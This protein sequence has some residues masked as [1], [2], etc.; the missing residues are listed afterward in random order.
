MPSI[1]R[2]LVRH[3]AADVG[4]R[5][6]LAI[7]ATL[8]FGQWMIRSFPPWDL[9]DAAYQ[10]APIE[11]APWLLGALVV[12]VLLARPLVR[13]L[14]CA[15]EVRQ[16][17]HLPIAAGRWRW[18]HG[19]QLVVL[20]LPVHAAV[21]YGV[22]PMHARADAC[23][24][25]LASI[26]GHVGVR[27]MQATLVDR[28]S[29]LR[30]FAG[31]AVAMLVG[32]VLVVADAYLAAALGSITAALGVRRLGRPFPEP[33]TRSS[34]ARPWPL[35]RPELARARLQLGCLWHRDRTMVWLTIGVQSA[36]V[37]LAAI[38]AEHLH[39]TFPDDARW[40][41]QLAACLAGAM[42]MWSAVRS[43]RAL[44]DDRWVLDPLIGTRAID[45][46]GRVIAAAVLAAPLVL[47]TLAAIAS[48]AHALPGLALFAA[49]A[50]VVWA[51]AASVELVCAAELRRALRRAQV[52]AI[53]ARVITL[54]VAAL[55]LGPLGVLM[56]ASVSLLRARQRW[57]LADRTRRR[58]AR[59][60][61]ELEVAA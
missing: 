25:L 59:L 22:W 47:A 29:W 23:A 13:R 11:R 28:G 44:A 5:Q 40:A 54:V 21:A 24:W 14:L 16:L 56:L 43:E 8:G 42:A 33:R 53:A 30:V 12:V 58:F 7:A 57:A 20:D 1:A 50:T 15:R 2:V 39:A 18:I 49:L 31:V 60:P 36:L 27:V 35:K 3:V 45:L 4:R 46:G 19:T 51:A 55:L 10:A 26:A 9:R 61:G 32:A 6:G 38:A 17:R 37:V 41:V 48:G 52:L 34:S